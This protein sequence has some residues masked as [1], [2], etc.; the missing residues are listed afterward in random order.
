MKEEEL[1]KKEVEE[2]KKWML[3]M[4]DEH[5]RYLS[6]EFDPS[7]SLL[8]LELQIKKF[9]NDYGR[10]LLEKAIPMTYG[11]GYY[12][13]KVEETDE[14]TK[15]PV[16]YSCMVR[17]NTRPLKTIFGKIAIKRAYYQQDE[18]GSSLGL[19]DKKLDIH[20]HNVSPGIR[21]YSDLFGITT[22]YREGRETIAKSLGIDICTKDLD[23]FTQEKASEIASHFEERTKGI[24]LGPNDKIE[25]AEID[26]DAKNQRIIY[27]E[28]DGCYVPI[29]KFR[30]E[31]DDWRECKSFLLFE[32][33]EGKE[34]RNRIKNKRCFSSVAGIGYFKK[35]AKLE[36][37]NY[38]RD[39]KVKIVCVGDGAT[40]I[41]KMVKELVPKGR[42]EVLDWFHVKE[43]I[44]KLAAELFPS[45]KKLVEKEE[46]V[47]DLK[48]HFY[49][50]EFDKGIKQLED[51]YEKTRSRKL[52]ARVSEVIEYFKN[53]RDRM[54]YQE[55]KKQGLC[56]GSGAIESTNKNV[57]H[58]RMRIPGCR[59]TLENADNIAHMR[60]EFM[61][62]NFDKWFN[63]ENNPMLGIA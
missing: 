23:I 6:K 28:T 49:N 35:Q 27:L 36:L 29:R 15:K 40:W 33:E 50:E 57:I 56:L 4:V 1:T 32:T 45:E 17:E 59:W 9:T 24:K 43:R 21:Y 39:D 41:W 37:E 54:K 58:R 25:P 8:K 10:I 60:A 22:S 30:D 48:G 5:V 18:N 19:L 53:N 34:N 16:H 46:F 55:Y 14:E 63:L 62:N 42:V 7:S 12:G 31:D 2:L 13:A 3:E 38:C 52:Q 26:A 61:N 20:K 47:D 44:T 51:Y 11:D